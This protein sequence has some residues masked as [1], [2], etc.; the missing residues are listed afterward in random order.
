MRIITNFLPPKES[1]PYNPA[2]NVHLDGNQAGQLIMN[3]MGGESFGVRRIL[4]YSPDMDNILVSARLNDD[5]YIFRDIQLSVVHTLFKS[6][7]GLFAPFVIQKNNTLVFELVNLGASAQ[8]VSIQL[9]GFDQHAM[10]KLQ[11]AYAQI[12][13]P[14]P[15]PRFLYGHTMVPVNGVNMNLGVKSK[16]VDVNVRRMAMASDRSGEIMASM[17]VYNTTVRSE[18]YIDQINDEFDGRY[19][20]VPFIVGANVPFDVFAS[21]RSGQVARVSFLSECYVVQHDLVSEEA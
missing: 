21:N 14:M 4:P 6:I 3:G 20:N 19:A 1:S 18:L 17:R 16:S 7:D 8:T 12:G 2:K 5:L 9:I 13:A 10:S 11:A 15:V